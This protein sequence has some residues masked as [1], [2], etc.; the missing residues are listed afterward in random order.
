MR[1]PH[2]ASARQPRAAT[3]CASAAGMHARLG[4]LCWRV[5]RRLLPPTATL[6]SG[7]MVGSFARLVFFTPT[8]ASAS[9]CLSC[10]RAGARG[11]A[12]RA[13]ERGF[14][15]LGVPIG[16]PEF[17]ERCSGE[18]LADQ[19]RLLAELPQLPDL[20]SAWLL[21]LFCAAPC[22]APPPHASAF[23]VGDLCCG[24]RPRH[25]GHTANKPSLASLGRIGL[26]PAPAPSSL[27]AWVALACC[28]RS[29]RPHQLTGAHMGG[30]PSR[31]GT[32]PARGC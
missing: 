9:C 3:C 6:I 15:A 2:L 13:P 11:V 1:R 18:R 14:V 25:V 17:V 30:L 10:R 29:A 32:T 26:T 7:H 22:A 8:I 31:H 20:Q 4:M 19:R 27:L 24:P 5:L 16:S 28:V 12:W 23:S 21:L